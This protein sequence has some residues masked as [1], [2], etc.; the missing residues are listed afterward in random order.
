MRKSLITV[1]GVLVAAIS[2][3]AVIATTSSARSARQASASVAS[4]ARYPASFKGIVNTASKTITKWAGPYT[5]PK[6]AKRK[7]LVFSIPCSNTATGCVRQNQGVKAAAKA[8]GWR[9]T[10]PVDPEGDP[11]K[12]ADAIQQAIQAKAN[13]IVLISIDP[14][15]VS[16][17]VAQARKA[18]IIVACASC[19]LPAGGTGKTGIS[20][21]ADPNVGNTG[22][23]LAAYTATTSG[24]S[25]KIAMLQDSEFLVVKQR[26]NTYLNLLKQCHNC[27][28][29]AKENFVS[30][31]VGPTLSDKG[32]SL[33]AANPSATYLYVGFD[34][35]AAP[36]IEGL[37]QAGK[38]SDLT[39]GK[40]RVIS[41]DANQQN[42][43]LVKQ[44]LQYGDI[45]IPLEWVAWSL[46]DQVNRLV[47]HRPIDGRESSTI[48]VKLITKANVG[49][50][51]AHGFTGDINYEAKY[52]RLWTAGKTNSA[53]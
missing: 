45:G 5:S 49:H 2:L 35:G 34:A 7:M 40:L 43:T 19:G 33:I 17:A 13:V 14:T 23:I 36:V 15:T 24:G 32:Q 26:Y 50:Y 52:T 21:D 37:Q 46:M 9:Y 12:A 18:G 38:A 48:P 47:Q 44:G 4:G 10:S 6:A 20:L 30:T 41:Y 53:S 27:S 11:R 8:L 28:V 29:V 1:V 42:L 25:A 51:L 31:D 39:S 16:T 22:R 3:G